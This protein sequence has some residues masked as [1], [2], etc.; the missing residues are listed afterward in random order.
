M[1]CVDELALNRR[2]SGARGDLES[3]VR[4]AGKL[5]TLGGGMGWCAIA[6]AHGERV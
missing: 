2:F 5:P 6:N 1:A 3:A 4:V